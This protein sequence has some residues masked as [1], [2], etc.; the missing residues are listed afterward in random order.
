MNPIDPKS[1]E[2]HSFTIDRLQAHMHADKAARRKG[3]TALQRAQLTAA[4]KLAGIQF[5]IIRGEADDK[6]AESLR[7]DL[8]ALWRIV[9][10][11]VLAFGEY[12]KEHFS[13]VDLAMFK[14]QLQGALDGNATFELDDIAAGIREQQAEHDAD[15]VS[16]AKAQRLECE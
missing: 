8:I 16:W 3:I 9:D 1:P 12:A 2:Q 13:S 15:P 11:L 14:D 5:T 6:D 4:G 7:D 10:P